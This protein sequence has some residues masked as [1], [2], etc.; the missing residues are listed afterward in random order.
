MITV[1][2][3]FVSHFFFLYKRAYTV[4]VGNSQYLEKIFSLILFVCSHNVN[5]SPVLQSRSIFL[6]APIKSTG[7]LFFQLYFTNF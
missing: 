1:R 5:V 3:K 6:L 2:I 7:T 4:F